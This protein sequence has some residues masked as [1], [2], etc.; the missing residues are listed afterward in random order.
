[1]SEIGWRLQQPYMQLPDK[2]YEEIEP[3]PVRDPQLVFLNG[4]LAQSL[5]LDPYK[6]QSE[7]GVQQ[8]VGNQLP[9]GARPISQAYAGHQFGSFTMLGDGRAHL[10]G[11]HVTSDGRRFDIQ[12]KGSGQTPYSRGGDGRAVLGP[13]LR[14]YV[15]SEA[16]HALGVPTNRSLAVSVTG[17]PVRREQTE[18]GAVLMRVSASHLRVGTFQ[19][20]RQ[21]GSVDD[22]KALADYALERHFEG[23]EE[24]DNRY[25]FLLEE[26]VKRQAKTVS[27]W[28]LIGFVHGV[29]NTDNMTI[30]GESIDYGPC[31]F[32]NTYDQETVFSSIDFYGRYKYGN[33]PKIAAWNL[34]RFAESL[35]PLIGDDDE[36]L[37]RAEEVVHRFI[38]YYRDE[39][40]RGMR[41][42][43]GLVN[44]EDADETLIDD[45]LTLM[46]EHEADFT[47]TFRGL[48]LSEYEGMALFQMDGFKEW[49]SRW[50][51]R[52]TRQEAKSDDV[53]EL[54]RQSNPAIIPRNNHVEAAIRA[55]EEEGDLSAMDDLLR[56]LSNPYAYSDE[57][58]AYTEPPDESD[59][60]FVTYCGT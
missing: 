43:L 4:N 30:S 31:A 40:M 32:M 13:M 15:I 23:Y 26:V 34:A 27:Q 19:Y 21:W 29:M 55:A 3:E 10:L 5:E 24:A 1:M 51:E 16:L 44:E 49:K 17:E 33:Q 7:E 35:L 20:A 22:L 11:E 60:D 9:H 18:I 57:Q 41:R 25:L 53:A 37:K 14:E 52:L 50:E 39:W 46:K 36:T 38:D 42:K 6:L 54:M 12:L 2:F 45:L 48:T 58:E 8:L 59:D 47:N 56:V 28:Q